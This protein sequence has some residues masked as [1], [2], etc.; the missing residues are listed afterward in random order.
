MCVLAL[1]FCFLEILGEL[2]MAA[3]FS[4]HDWE[5]RNNEMI[6]LFVFVLD[7]IR[8]SGNTR[9]SYGN[10]NFCIYNEFVLLGIYVSC[11]EMKKEYL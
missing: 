9:F 7:D 6:L 2:G 8:A 5:S 3:G 4:M 1:E 10:T 11:I